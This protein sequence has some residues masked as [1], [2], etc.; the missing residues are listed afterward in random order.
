LVV[1]ELRFFSAPPVIHWRRSHAG[2]LISACSVCSAFIKMVIYRSIV[3]F[4][5]CYVLTYPIVPDH[6]SQPPHSPHIVL[7][8]TAISFVMY[9]IAGLYT[10]A[11]FFRRYF[12]KSLSSWAKTSVAQMSPGGP[13]TPPPHKSQLPRGP[14]PTM[15]QNRPISLVGR[16]VDSPQYAVVKCLRLHSEQR[17]SRVS[18]FGL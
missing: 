17:V 4:P 1:C 16:H 6:Q 2:A 14:R 15:M 7:R 10:C 12:K 5:P 3:L 8:A 11:V 18:M 9:L 13:H